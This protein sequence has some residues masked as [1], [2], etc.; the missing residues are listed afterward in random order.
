M[1]DGS[2]R[3]VPTLNPKNNAQT[4][5]SPSSRVVGTGRDNVLKLRINVEL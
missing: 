3:W 4:V 2:G 1:Y 5:W